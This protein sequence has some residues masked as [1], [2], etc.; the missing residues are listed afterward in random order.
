MMSV[1]LISLLWVPM[2]F[3]LCIINYGG[4]SE[5]QWWQAVVGLTPALGVMIG[6]LLK[7]LRRQ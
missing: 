4:E 5:L 2:W 1:L 3:M 7:D 6:I